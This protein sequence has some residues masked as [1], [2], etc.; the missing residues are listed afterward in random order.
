MYN[1][2]TSGIY[3][4]WWVIENVTDTRDGE[5]VRK[6]HDFEKKRIDIARQNYQRGGGIRQENR[7]IKR[8]G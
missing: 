8:D 4:T 2:R 6:I 7:K 1:F 3:F 5:N